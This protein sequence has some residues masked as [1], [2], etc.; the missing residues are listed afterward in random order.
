[1]QFDVSAPP[2]IILLETPE[3]LAVL[4]FLVIPILSIAPAVRLADQSD[5]VVEQHGLNLRWP[6]LSSRGQ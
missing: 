1:M 6:S 2:Q 4:W 3:Y 5:Q